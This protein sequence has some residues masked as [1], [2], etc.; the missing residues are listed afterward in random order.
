MTTPPLANNHISVDIV[1]LGFDGADLRALLLRRQGEDE[2]GRFSDMKLPGS[3]IY[4]DENLDEAA[5]RVL[6]ELTGDG[7]GRG[8]HFEYHCAVRGRKGVKRGSG[9][10]YA[11][12]KL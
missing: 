3:L 10:P 4:Q 2:G 9:G 5:V 12:L 11:L 1:I 6:N 8:D 7:Q